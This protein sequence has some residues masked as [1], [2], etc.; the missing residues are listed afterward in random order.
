MFDLLDDGEDAIAPFDGVVEDESDNR[1]PL[2]AEVAAEDLLESGG[3]GFETVGG[4]LALGRGTDEAHERG[5]G[6][7]VRGHD[8]VVD[9]QEA[10]LLDGE[11]ASDDL[12]HFTAEQLG[13]PNALLIAY[14]LDVEQRNT[15]PAEFRALQA[16]IKYVRKLLI[17]HIG[18]W[19]RRR[20]AL[21][22]FHRFN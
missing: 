15:T 22:A 4:G 17:V 14:L 3:A 7:E 13:L 10:G 8:H 12:R 21:M 1:G 20:A 16:R 18:A 11:V 9:R 5:G 6:P 2:Q 19:R